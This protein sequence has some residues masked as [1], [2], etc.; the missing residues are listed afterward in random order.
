MCSVVVHSMHVASVLHIQFVLF[1]IIYFFLFSV[2]KGKIPGFREGEAIFF[3]NFMKVFAKWNE[4][5]FSFSTTAISIVFHE[6][7]KIILA[8]KLECSHAHKSIIYLQLYE[9]V[10]EFSTEKIP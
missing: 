2:Q 7:K 1:A 9:N 4:I 8:A 5:T 3:T 6:K 10:F